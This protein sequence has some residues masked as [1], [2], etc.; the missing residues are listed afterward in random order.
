MVGRKGLIALPGAQ[1]TVFTVKSQ[2]SDTPDPAGR[3]PLT[4]EGHG[5][6]ELAFNWVLKTR[7]WEEH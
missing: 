5:R 2:T 3:W 1:W 6:R 7:P 4:P